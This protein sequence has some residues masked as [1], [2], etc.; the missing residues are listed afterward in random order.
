[1]RWDK[2][3]FKWILKILHTRGWELIEEVNLLADDR[4]GRDD[5]A[6]EKLRK[7]KA[8]EVK[9][10]ENKRMDPRRV[11]KDMQWNFTIVFMA[12]F[13]AKFREMSIVSPRLFD[14]E[15]NGSRMNT[16]F[17]KCALWDG[18]FWKSY[19]TKFS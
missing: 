12:N 9:S 11:P 10:C 17:P 18:P 19:A 2:I 16:S 4:E 14:F 8:R 15:D 1:M 5:K 13:I 7:S 3:Q 6:R